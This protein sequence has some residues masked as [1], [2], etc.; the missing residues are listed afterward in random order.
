[1]EETF[2]PCAAIR[3]APLIWFIF[4]LLSRASY[5]NR[6]ALFL[7]SRGRS[8]LGN[9]RF[10]SSRIVNLVV[11]IFLRRYTFVVSS[12]SLFLFFILVAR[13]VCVCLYSSLLETPAE[14]ES[15]MF[16]AKVYTESYVCMCESAALYAGE[17]RKRKRT[18]A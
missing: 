7:T 12:P 5:N 1:M 8:P 13:C 16:T 9:N 3:S 2:Y 4:H 18:R 17:R 6:R 10:N 15:S 11:F 14:I